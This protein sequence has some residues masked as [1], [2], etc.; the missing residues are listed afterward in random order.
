MSLAAAECSCLFQATNS[1][2]L[3]RTD[4]CEWAWQ[5]RPG[6]PKGIIIVCKLCT[7]LVGSH[8]LCKSDLHCGEHSFSN[9]LINGQKF[10]FK[11]VSKQ[12][13]SCIFA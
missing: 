11:F 3:M 8:G 13:L 7:S 6:Q 4:K 9:P 2:H 12:L 5:W 1:D 10:N